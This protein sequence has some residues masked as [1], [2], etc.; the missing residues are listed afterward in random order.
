MA[1]IMLDEDQIETL[2]SNIKS[3]MGLHFVGKD[4][5]AFLSMLNH[6]IRT[7]FTEKTGEEPDESILLKKD[8]IEKAEDGYQV[9]FPDDDLSALS[10]LL[11]QD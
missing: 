3:E 10:A 7:R 6:I 1:L 2:R 9:N 4:V 5:D 11:K 8:D